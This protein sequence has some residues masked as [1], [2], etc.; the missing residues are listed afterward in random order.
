M[1][2]SHE[3]C[4]NANSTKAEGTHET[5]RLH[6]SD[7]YS[8]HLQVGTSPLLSYV[9]VHQA[10]FTSAYSCK[11]ANPRLVTTSLHNIVT[12]TCKSPGQF[13]SCDNSTNICSFGRVWAGDYDDRYISSFD[14]KIS[15]LVV[16]AV[17]DIYDNT[18]NSTWRRT[19]IRNVAPLYIRLANWP[20]NHVD[21][22][23]NGSPT[24]EG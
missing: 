13:Q 8:Y 5:E 18:A 21:Y 9:K 14:G 10:Y 6:A 23:R 24:N 3:R 12:S 11:Q 16:Q 7:R 1:S 19:F 20:F 2:Q 22:A 4:I 17:D 15:K